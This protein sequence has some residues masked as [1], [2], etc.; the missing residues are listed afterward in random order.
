M[1]EDAAA[2]G[3]GAAAA[4]PRVEV[5]GTEYKPLADGEYD[6]IVL[7]TGTTECV[8]SGLFAVG[9]KRVLVVDRN[10]FYGAESASLNLTNLFQKFRG[11]EPTEAQFNELG[12]NRD[13][14]VDLIPKFLLSCGNLVKILLHTKVTA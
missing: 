1:A 11:A 4:D 5:G 9:K 14:N 8:L 2:A 12:S 3:G 10:N 7:G 6:V 13:F